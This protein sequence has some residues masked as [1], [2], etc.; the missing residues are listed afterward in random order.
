MAN[1]VLYSNITDARLT[2]V[3]SMEMQL[4][5]A[6][7]ASLWGHPSIFYAG[8]A[9][10][11]GSTTIKVPIP[12]LN[13]VNR[14]A[15]VAENASVVNTALTNTSVSI[16]IARQALQRSMSDIADLTDSVG[17][18]IG[19]FVADMSGAAAMRFQ[20]M[21]VEL[22]DGFTSTVGTTAV[23]MS[24]DDQFSAQFTLTQASVQGPV[25]ECLFPVQLTD[26]QNSV[27]AEAGA[28]QFQPATA[29][30]LQL[31][32][33]GYAGNLNGADIF[34][35]SLV[36]TANAGA[37]SAAGMWSAG[38]VGYADGIPRPVNA[39]SGIVY[40]AGSKVL[41]ELQRDTS[42]ALTKITGNYYVGLA[43]MQQGMGVSIITD[44]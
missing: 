33:Q 32:G 29:E 41:V 16:T 5:L 28:F 36:P 38:A 22:T 15:A 7:R 9:S 13:G 25:I 24:V 18:N 40:P 30:M 2:A 10:L 23:D 17:I 19:T 12:S 11:R 44:R 34:A 31:K 21:L 20:A 42:G 26:L 39:G 27:R 1:E 14:M 3:L 37:D 8:S 35:S 6:D 43:I 4:A